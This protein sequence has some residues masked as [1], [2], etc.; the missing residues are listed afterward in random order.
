MIGERHGC[1]AGVG[2]CRGTGEDLGGG[3]G[4]SV[5]GWYVNV[6]M[7]SSTPRPFVQ[8]KAPAERCMVFRPCTTGDP[9]KWKIMILIPTEALFAGVPLT[10]KSLAPTKPFIK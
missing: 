6:H 3:V 8:V 10:V 1:R 4:V 2:R 7:N 5:D 9:L